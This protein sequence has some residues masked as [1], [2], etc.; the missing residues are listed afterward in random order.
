MGVC[1]CM[2]VCPCV[3]VSG[4]ACACKCKEL[5]YTTA[6]STLVEISI[7]RKVMRDCV[8]REEVRRIPT[9]E[10]DR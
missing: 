3:C 4:S 2:C 1:V 7:M 6:L 5:T 10:Y 8:D 9:N